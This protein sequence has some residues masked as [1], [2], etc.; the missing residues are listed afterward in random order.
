[1]QSGVFEVLVENDKPSEFGRLVVTSFFTKGTPLIRYDIGDSLILEKENKI[2]GC[3]NN[4]PLVKSILG[5]IDDYVY[6]PK[7]GKINLGNISN[8]LKGTNGIKSF[9]VVQDS[10]DELNIYLVVDTSAYNRNIEKVFI[11]NWIERVGK[12]MQIKL[13]Q[14]NDIPIESSGK[15]RIVKNNIK[16]LIEN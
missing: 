7:M 4:N 3:G 13:H 2:C 6:S 12:Q 15:F 14:V 9:Q 5:R 10:L 11:Q 8:T 16:H 1:L